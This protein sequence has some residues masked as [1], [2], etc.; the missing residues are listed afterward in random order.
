MIRQAGGN[1]CIQNKGVWVEVGERYTRDQVATL[2][3]VTCL[4]TQYRSSN[5][6]KVARRRV[7]NLNKKQENQQFGQQQ[8]IHDTAGP[9]SDDT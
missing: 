8:L 9:P 6:T 2:L 7:R 5:K 3:R 4:H 1:F